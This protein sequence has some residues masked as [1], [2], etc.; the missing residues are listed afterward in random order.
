MLRGALGGRRGISCPLSIVVYS[1]GAR[2][3]WSHL[4]LSKIFGIEALKDL[5]P[6]LA[7]F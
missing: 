3:T 6:L 4:I 2:A 1:V 5:L 7:L